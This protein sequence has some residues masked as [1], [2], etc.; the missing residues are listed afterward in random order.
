[1]EAAKVSHPSIVLLKNVNQLL[2]FGSLLFLSECLANCDEC[3]SPAKCNRGKC[4]T[5][6]G[7]DSTGACTGMNYSY[8]CRQIIE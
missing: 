5:G 1:M 8:N 7:L 3:S 2:P 4:T 6:F